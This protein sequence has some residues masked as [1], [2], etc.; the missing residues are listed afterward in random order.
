MTPSHY[1]KSI[2]EY[3]RGEAGPLA[4]AISVQ[5]MPTDEFLRAKL[6][7]VN[8]LHTPVTPERLSACFDQVSLNLEADR[9]FHSH[10]TVNEIACIADAIARNGINRVIDAGCG[11]GLDLGYLAQRFSRVEFIGYDFS[12]AAI[13][14]ARK[15]M[16]RLKRKN[17]RLEV[18]AHDQAA[19]RFGQESCDLVYAFGS[20]FTGIAFPEREIDGDMGAWAEQQRRDPYVIEHRVILGNFSALLVP[21]GSCHI[22]ATLEEGRH[23]MVKTIARQQ[24]LIEVRS[25]HYDS[26]K[27]DSLYAEYILFQKMT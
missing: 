8:R 27:K 3:L 16:T 15:R 22:G 13:D 2:G 21:G 20:L 1:A 17:V 6:D 25:G 7:L 23:L 24:R 10:E 18:C 12:P 4:V 5:G 19:E 11:S 14:L 26:S 9:M